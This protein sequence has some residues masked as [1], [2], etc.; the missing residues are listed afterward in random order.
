MPTPMRMIAVLLTKR[1][2]VWAQTRT[3]PSRAPL[4]GVLRTPAKNPMPAVPARPEPALCLPA[5]EPGNV[6]VITSNI[7]NPK[8][9]I[10]RNRTITAVG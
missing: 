7:A 4:Q 9:T 1:V 10:A 2:C 5:T 6:S 3:K 8:K